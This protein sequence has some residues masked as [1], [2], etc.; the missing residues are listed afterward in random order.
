MAAET[1]EAK[2]G[3][4]KTAVVFPGQGSQHL[5]MLSGY[6]GAP[7]VAAA[8]A[9][10]GEALGVDLAGIMEGD[11]A[12]L[13]DTVNTQPAMLAVSV[14][15]YR[16]VFGG[17]T[18]ALPP[19]QIA[20]GHSVG[21]YAALVCAGVLPLAEAAKLVAR[22]AELMR[23]AVSDGGMAAVL[24]LSAEKAEAVC[25]SLHEKGE[26]VWPANYNSD[27]QI[28]L[29]GR[30]A[31]L[32]RAAEELKSAG[33]KRVITVPMSVPSHCPLLQ[34]AADAFIA[35]LQ[36]INWQEQAFA[37]LCN[38]RTQREFREPAA[39][40]YPRSLAAQLVR[41]VFWTD[42]LR[43]FVWAEVSQVY[44]CGPGKVLCGLG[45][46]SGLPHIPLNNAAAIEAARGARAE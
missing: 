36:K 39:D 17:G 12:A 2:T 30:K 4:A 29:A 9:E 42:I 45:K 37:V 20:A 13:N 1:A 35:D 7:Q 41:P 33:A 23:D 40:F 31:A 14:G 18:P 43:R 19:P 25:N 10:A 3:A 26:E 46:K 28:V 24:G 15:V 32:N 6:G 5:G 34:P 44:E 38:S 16:A 11:E 21:E 27:G 22:R 8:V